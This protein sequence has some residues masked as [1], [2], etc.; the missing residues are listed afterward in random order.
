MPTYVVKF[1]MHCDA[2]MEIEADNPDTARKKVEQQ[3]A[4]GSMI[5]LELSDRAMPYSITSVE[6]VEDG[7]GFIVLPSR[8]FNGVGYGYRG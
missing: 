3:L 4:F 7:S 2:K 6:A 8:I 1:I 5:G